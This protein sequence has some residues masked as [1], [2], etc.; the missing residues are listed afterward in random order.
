ME[1][2]ITAMAGLVALLAMGC[3][4]PEAKMGRGISDVM[5]PLRLGEV[6][7]AVE[8]EGV[9]NGSSATFRGAVHG[10]NRSVCRT[11][12]GVYEIITAPIPPYTPVLKHADPAFPDNY[13]PGLLAD[14]LFESSNLLGYGDGE[15]FPIL[16]GNRFRIFDH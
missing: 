6:R 11:A 12:V 9:Y 4:G 10:L 1:H 13:E 16:P 14:P 5:E 15:V 2:K 3:A 8:Q 7:Y